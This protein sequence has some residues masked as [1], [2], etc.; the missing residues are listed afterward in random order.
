M[1]EHYTKIQIQRQEELTKAIQERLA[2]AAQGTVSEQRDPPAP[3]KPPAGQPPA[4]SPPE[5]PPSLPDVP[6][7]TQVL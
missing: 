1:T 6:M 3:P 2:T 4:S 7:A 5:A